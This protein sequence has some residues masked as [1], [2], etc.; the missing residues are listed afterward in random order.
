MLFA[1]LGNYYQ[2]YLSFQGILWR[3]MKR[4]LKKSAKRTDSDRPTPSHVVQGAFV[5]KFQRIN[6]LEFFFII[7]S[8]QMNSGFHCKLLEDLGLAEKAQ[9]NTDHSL[10]LK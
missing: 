6:W 7:R 9:F 4:C 2:K 10:K 5:R 3:R 1:F 8:G